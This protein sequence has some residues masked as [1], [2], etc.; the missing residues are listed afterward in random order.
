M[1]EFLYEMREI[2]VAI[3]TFLDEYGY[4]V[5]L[6]L[7]LII[8][9]KTAFVILTFLPG[10]ATAFVGGTLIA[11][12]ELS[13][14]ILVPLLLVATVLGDLQNYSL[15]RFGRRMTTRWRPMP[16]KNI[17]SAQYFLEEYGAR[18]I[19]FARFIPFMRTTIPFVTGYM[20]YPLKAFV[21]LNS[22]GGAMWVILWISMGMLLGQIPAVGENMAVSLPLISL[23]PFVL[24]ISFYIVRRIR[25]RRVATS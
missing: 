10:D 22:I 25:K 23:L 4:L 20:G 12:G 9:C 13:I 21:T 15:G 16:A 5:Y 2:D 17:K 8:Y 6:L 14:W 18:G 11:L 19:V 3:Q 7:F 1:R 24:P